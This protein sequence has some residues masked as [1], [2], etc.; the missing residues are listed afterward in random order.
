MKAYLYV[1]SNSYFQDQTVPRTTDVDYDEVDLLPDDFPQ[2]YLD[3]LG[4]K[5]VFHSHRFVELLQVIEGR[6]LYIVDKKLCF[7]EP[8]DIIFFNSF[9]P[10]SRLFLEGDVLINDYSFS[11]MLQS[12]AHVN[13]G[14][15]SDNGTQNLR[16]K[17]NKAVTVFCGNDF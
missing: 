14:S 7:L 9:I 3:M 12:D 11:N 4:G 17:I 1:E 10:H 16:F 15:S 5:V 6:A 8:G 13:R 2:K